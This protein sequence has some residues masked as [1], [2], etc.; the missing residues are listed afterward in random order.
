MSPT[1]AA[2]YTFA[3]AVVIWLI[4]FLL[5][6]FR[7]LTNAVM[8][9]V[10]VSYGMIALVATAAVYRRAERGYSVSFRRQV[11][12]LLITAITV[13]LLAVLIG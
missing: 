9:T 7:Y 3:I 13:Y 8:P 1:K 10:L 2:W 5:F 11:I 6:N 12:S 4:Y